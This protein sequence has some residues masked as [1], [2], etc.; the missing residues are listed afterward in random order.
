LE[1]TNLVPTQFIEE[2]FRHQVLLSIGK[3]VDE[4]NERNRHRASYG[5]YEWDIE[6][7][8]NGILVSNEN[9]QVSKNQGCSH[10]TIL[11][12][13]GFTKGVHQ[14]EILLLATAGCYSCVGVATNDFNVNSGIL[15]IAPPSVSTFG[16]FGQGQSAPSW[17]WNMYPGYVNNASPNSKAETKK[18]MLQSGAKVRL[19]LDLQRCTLSIYVDQVLQHVFNDVKANKE[20]YPALTICHNT[21]GEGYLLTNGQEAETW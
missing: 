5:L 11:G 21:G 3:P 20:L 7:K 16:A 10:S 8:G 18:G 4:S 9:R 19:V 1:E 17:G 12:K 2:A 14:W 15:G 6:R 13:T